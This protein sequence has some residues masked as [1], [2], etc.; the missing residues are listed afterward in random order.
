MSLKCRLNVKNVA[1]SRTSV[2]NWYLIKVLHV[3]YTRMSV[4]DSVHCVRS[5]DK[6]AV[7]KSY[8]TEDGLWS[9][10]IRT[11]DDFYVVEVFLLS[12]LI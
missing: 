7:V 3:S 10:S 11:D 2:V 4:I 9:V 6:S 5:D 1:I 8:I 12:E